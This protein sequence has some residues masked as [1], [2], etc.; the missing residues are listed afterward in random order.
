MRFAYVQLKH[1]HPSKIET[2][3]VFIVDAF[4]KYLRVPAGAT[5]RDLKQLVAEKIELHMCVLD[6]YLFEVTPSLVRIPD[7]NELIRDITAKWSASN[8]SDLI[9]PYRFVFK[10]AF[11]LD[12]QPEDFSEDESYRHLM[13]LQA[14]QTIQKTMFKIP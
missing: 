6:Y 12:N 3:Q 14:Q 11:F 9:P 5:I 10:R 13:F 4:A 1:S 8:G 2:V 7:E